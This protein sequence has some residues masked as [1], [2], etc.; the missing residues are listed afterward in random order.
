[1]KKP[2][3]EI[4]TIDKRQLTVD[5]SFLNS[6]VIWFN[7]TVMAKYFNRRPADW[8]KLEDTKEYILLLSEEFGSDSGSIPE[9]VKTT[10]GGK[11][12]GTWFHKSLAIPFARWL[13]L[14]FAM[15]LD[16]W[17][18]HRIE[19]EHRRKLARLESK[20]GFLPMTNAILEAHEDIKGYH[21][22]N[23]SNMINNI[24]I[25]LS[26]KKFKEEY[27]T[28]SVR[29]HLTPEQL[30]RI[31]ELQEINTSLIK[32]G[33]KYKERKEKLTIF[34]NSKKLLN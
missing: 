5:V 25:G 3:Y 16:K 12:Q 31:K 17:I 10:K 13:S 22:S 18:L 24:V 6:D 34:F 32:I 28:D 33:A 11:Y 2:K 19:E 21:F 14:K 15:K 26:A 4:T 20:T 30:I 27:G 1:M 8:L 9:L 7:A 23:E 29:D